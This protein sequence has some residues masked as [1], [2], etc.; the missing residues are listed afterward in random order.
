M[1][2][3]YADLEMSLRI[4]AQ[5]E[6]GAV[7]DMY[8]FKVGMSGRETDITDFLTPVERQD[9]SKWALDQ[10][11]KT[12]KRTHESLTPD[13]MDEVDRIRDFDMLRAGGDR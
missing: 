13:P 3:T 9:L 4:E 2:E 5:I 11:F 8:V 7:V 1:F 12:N 10:Y 6:Y